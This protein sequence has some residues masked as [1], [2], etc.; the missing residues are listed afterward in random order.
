MAMV[1]DFQCPPPSLSSHQHQLAT[2]TLQVGGNLH[3][4]NQAS[5]GQWLAAEGRAPSNEQVWHRYVHAQC[6][7]SK[8]AGSPPSSR[9]NSTWAVSDATIIASHLSWMGADHRAV[10]SRQASSAT[11]TK[12]HAARAGNV[13]GALDTLDRIARRYKVSCRETANL[14]DGKVLETMNAFRVCPNGGL[15]AARSCSIARLLGRM[16]PQPPSPKPKV[17]EA[18]PVSGYGSLHKVGP[19]NH[20]TMTTSVDGDFLPSLLLSTK[21][22]CRIQ[23]TSQTRYQQ[24]PPFPQIAILRDCVEE[25]DKD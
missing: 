11:L 22:I 23:T 20:T 24:S 21:N 5:G 8:N 18:A 15:R 12:C 25:L 17:S 1:Q 14:T 3:T 10:F 4:T 13:V 7:L 2:P 16:R 6:T 9:I 19:V